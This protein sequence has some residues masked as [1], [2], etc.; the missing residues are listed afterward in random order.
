LRVS[1]ILDV[2][3]DGRISVDI[4]NRGA[5]AMARK[6]SKG[7]IAVETEAKSIRLEL[8]PHVHRNFRV[9]A[10]KEGMSMAAVA[11]RLVNE[12][13]KRKQGGR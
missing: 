2:P 6:Q 5:G 11:R 12:Y 4:V 7:M 10:A 8:P 9:E 3:A 1:Y 13:L